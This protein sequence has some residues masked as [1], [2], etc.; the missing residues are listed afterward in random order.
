MP[1]AEIEGTPAPVGRIARTYG[2]LKLLRASAISAAAVICADRR[3]LWLLSPWRF[4]TY[5]QL[6][7][8]L[9]A[10]RLDLDLSFALLDELSG[11]H[12]G[13][14]AK[15]LAAEESSSVHPKFLGRVSLAA[16]LGALG[17][18]LRLEED[19][20]ALERI[21][22]RLVPRYRAGGERHTVLH[23]RQPRPAAPV[24]G[25]AA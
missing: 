5:R 13:Y 6:V 3:G 22:P 16:I 14:S 19:P 10:R 4:R 11:L 7:D 15:V 17:L 25:Q 23:V 21:K 1:A 2:R 12:S 9:R 18:R 8:A 24:N 20:A